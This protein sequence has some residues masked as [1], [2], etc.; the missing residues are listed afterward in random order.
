MI[1]V[2]IFKCVYGR[3]IAFSAEMD[4]PFPCLVEETFPCFLEIILN[5]PAS[6]ESCNTELTSE[7][8]VAASLMPYKTSEDA[9]AKEM[10]STK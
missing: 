3:D 4:L 6:E 1:I 10:L 5:E 7:L 2:Q 8:I 9:E